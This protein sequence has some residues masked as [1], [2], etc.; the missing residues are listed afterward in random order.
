MSGKWADLRE[1]I[2][3][4]AAAELELG[5]DYS[6]TPGGDDR[7]RRHWERAQA[8]SEVLALMDEADAEEQAQAHFDQLA[9]EARQYPEARR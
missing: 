3:R 8:F 1:D 6:E 2:A 5:D 9:E 4:S 7:A